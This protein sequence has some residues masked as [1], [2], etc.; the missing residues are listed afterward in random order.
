[1]NNL[2]RDFQ[3]MVRLVLAILLSSCLPATSTETSLVNP[4]TVPTAS[5]AS[6]TT[7]LSNTPSPFS[8]PTF[9]TAQNLTNASRPTAIPRLSPPRP[10]GD[11]EQRYLGPEGW[12]SVYIPADWQEGET[13]GFYSG[14]DG[15]VEIR[16]L[17][18]LGFMEGIFG[19]YAWLA[20]IVEQPENTNISL[21][22]SMETT[23]ETGEKILQVVFK[24]PA[25]EYEQRFVLIKAYEAHIGRI[26]GSFRWLRPEGQPT[27]LD[28]HQMAPR[29]EDVSFW[30]SAGLLPQGLTMHEFEVVG[31]PQTDR[32][33]YF[34]RAH[35]PLE[36]RI[37][38]DEL[39]ERYDSS[40]TEGPGDAE[41]L[42]AF[43]YELSEDPETNRE[44]L[45]RD[46][47]L[48][49]ENVRSV[50]GVTVFPAASGESLV[51][52][53]DA[54]SGDDES[55]EHLSYIVKD[56]TIIEREYRYYDPYWFPP[57]MKDGELLWVRFSGTH[58]RVENIRGEIVFDFS[59]VV[60]SSIPLRFFK[61][62][63]NHWLLGV[64]NFII[65][66]GEILNEKYGYEAAFNWTVVN[67]KPLYFFRKGNRMGVSYDG[68]ILPLYYHAIPYGYCCGLTVNN[69]QVW[70]DS[71]RFFGQRDGVWHIVMMEFE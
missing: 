67:G 59:T 26:E 8:T 3:Q 49:L 9:T 36:A 35:I 4:P 22:G 27:A 71:V 25:A 55:R 19:V 17:P 32:Y 54:V 34:K 11:D 30:D 52:V 46:G 65:Q 50:D 7:P 40:R 33:L 16:C 58:V 14:P 63:G 23:T 53:V 56:H 37:V 6:P 2:K 60:G 10:M 45:Y 28:F 44:H 38:E 47:K 61:S 20:N 1:M 70:G 18:E 5:S 68:E 13:P 31:D 15:F 57:L 24:N 29:P 43:G 62:W 42:A 39:R 66:D 21:A 48:I 64:D 41:I 12:F 51:F 69:P